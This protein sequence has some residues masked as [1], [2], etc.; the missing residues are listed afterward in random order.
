M[1]RRGEGKR[2]VEREK[3]ETGKEQM[4]RK[5]GEQKLG[6]GKKREDKG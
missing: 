2:R 5:R 1:E 6:N 3:S 4:G